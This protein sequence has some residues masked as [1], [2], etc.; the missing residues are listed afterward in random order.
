MACSGI[1]RE[2]RPNFW[3]TIFTDTV[4]YLK[5]LGILASL[6]Q[7]VCEEGTDEALGILRHLCIVGEDQRVLVVHDLPVGPHQRLG[8]EGS[9][10]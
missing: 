7:P 3:P 9:L 4:K 1:C 2:S 5:F 10:T 8:V 6:Y